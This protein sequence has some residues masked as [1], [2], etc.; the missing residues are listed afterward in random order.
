MCIRD[1]LNLLT[2][3]A[4]KDLEAKATKLGDGMQAAFDAAG[5]TA[6][7]P[8]V[9]SLLGLYF[10][11]TAPTNFDEADAAA[12][13]GVYPKFFHG[14]LERGFAFAP[15]PYEAI[16]VSLAHDDAVIDQTIAA[17]AEVAQTL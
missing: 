3:D 7:V 15:G 8:R 2:P 1:R 13:N 10:T 12:T 16:F 4:Y 9:G 5:V 6:V 14:M 11:D 17:C